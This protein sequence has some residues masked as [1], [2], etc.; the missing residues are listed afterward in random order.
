M[1]TLRALV[2]AIGFVAVPWFA[3]AH[4]RALPRVV[5]T[6]PAGVSSEKVVLDYVLYGSFGADG[7]YGL[8]S[9]QASTY[10]IYASSSHGKVAAKIKIIVWAPGCKFQTFDISLDE[11]SDIQQPF[12]C[13]PLPNVTVNGQLRLSRIVP[14]N[15]TEITFHYLAGWAC[16][17]FGF[18][19]CMVPQFDMGAAVPNAEGSFEIVLPDFSA[20]PVAT[21]MDGDE[22]FS[23]TL[24]ETKTWNLV[25][26]L[27]PESID[28]RTPG[29]NLRVQSAYPKSLAFLPQKSNQQTSPH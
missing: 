10:T 1:H 15:P 16:R 21:E 9:A 6:L 26:F 2:V 8:L 19:D 12:L 18:A 27:E 17:F 11:H 22:E 20:D 13:A 14:G 29:R 3:H 23:L 4:G 25:T 5:I 7:S 28:V 24:R